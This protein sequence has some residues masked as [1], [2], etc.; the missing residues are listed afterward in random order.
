MRPAACSS[1]SP[2]DGPAA[3]QLDAEPDRRAALAQYRARASVYNFEL[4]LLEP[5][6]REA[7]SNVVAHLKPAAHVVAAGL[8]WA[9]PWTWP[10]N[11]FVLLAA[12][13]S[14]TSLEGLD[15]PWDKLAGLVGS[16]D[17]QTR[18]MGA[19]YIASGARGKRPRRASA[20]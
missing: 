9:S 8:Q 17:V 13:H 7:I 16:L 1:S 15:R 4:A 2:I 3:M 19:I 12:L 14:T 5:I 11:W 10:A 6:R 20:R 18:C